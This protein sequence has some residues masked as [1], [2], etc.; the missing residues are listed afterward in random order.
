MVSW[1]YPMRTLSNNDVWFLEVIQWEHFQIMTYGFLKLSNENELSNN[2]VW[3]LE[4]IQWE[5]F[6]IMTYGFLKLSNENTFK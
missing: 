3:F 6:Q 4:V 2:D 5:H 1:S